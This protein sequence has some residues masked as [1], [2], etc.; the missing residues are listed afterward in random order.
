[1]MPL[2]NIVAIPAAVCG[3]TLFYLEQSEHK[4]HG[5]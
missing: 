4:R 5:S 2:I 1:M 3:G